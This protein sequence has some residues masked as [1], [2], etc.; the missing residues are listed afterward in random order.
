MM[1]HLQRFLIFLVVAL[2]VRAGSSNSLLDVQ[3]DGKQLL[4]ANTDNNSITVV[5]IVARKAIREIK[6]GDHP[7]GVSWIS[8]GPFAIV[9]L[10]REDA[11]VIVD[12]GSGKI[13]HR[14]DKLNE[15]YG[16]VT[17]KDGKKA[18]V[19][20]D[21]PGKVVEIDLINRKVLRQLSAGEWARGIAIDSSE[22]T[23]FVSNFYTAGLTAID[24]ETG[25]IK[26]TWA[27]LK[28]DN[29]ARQVELHPT[30]PKAYLAHQQSRTDV[31]SA[32]G[33]IFP[34]LTIYTTS[35]EQAG[36]SR[37]MSIGLDTYNGV[38]VMATPW[39][40]AISPDGKYLITIYAGS[41]DCNLHEVVNDDYREVTR[42]NRRA[43]SIGKNPRAVRFSPD[44]KTAFIYNTLDFAVSFHSIP[45][46]EKLNEVV[47]C[48]PPHTPAW[49]QGKFLFNSTSP[50]LTA[51]RWVACASCHPDGLADGKIWEN[52]EGLRKTPALAGLA[53]THPLHW[54][55]DRD[56]VQDFEYTIR[57]K[58][59]MGR[60]LAPKFRYKPRTEFQEPS[61][62]EERLSDRS[63]ALDALAVYTNSFP[64]RLSPHI[65]EK[66]KLSEEAQRGKELFFNN[67]VACA[68]CHTGPY[69]TDSR[70]QKP[71]LLHDVGTGND[72]EEKMGPKY[73]TPSLIGLY[74]TAPY[75]HHGKATTIM[76]VLTTF[77]TKDQHGK[78]S[79]LSMQQKQDLVE[80]L[81]ALPY[82]IPPDETPNTV[83]YRIRREE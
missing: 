20:L 58:L 52:P 30:R 46:M 33:S 2:P 61:E 59:M 42:N 19:S 38:Y 5:D 32:R 29:L 35:P 14:F 17:T 3:P 71:F 80:F 4:T 39:E 57:G 11:V 26:D 21:Y 73:D 68:K 10:Y 67:D 77:N 9:T 60:G 37:R 53:H 81:K 65:P 70:L 74:R 16:V 27:G 54:S 7:E 50:P 23:L 82:D 24:L 44:S 55:A 75:L 63:P 15:P 76:D 34:Q 6:V 13:V 79:H 28:S 83:K 8:A 47:V 41:E 48:Q 49:V 78:T 69:Y 36:K 40:T 51:Q 25:K 64:T 1:M 18:Y 43:T 45:S 12:T 22:K 66:G 31:F 56:E 62:L 72:P